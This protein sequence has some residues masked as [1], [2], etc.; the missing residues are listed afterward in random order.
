MIIAKLYEEIFGNIH[1]SGGFFLH[2]T[3]KFRKYRAMKKFAKKHGM[4]EDY[5]GFFSITMKHQ[6]KPVGLFCLE[7]V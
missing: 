6:N 3:K 7:S 4:K 5:K 1:N 2:E